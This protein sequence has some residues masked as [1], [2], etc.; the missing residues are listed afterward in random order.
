MAVHGIAKIM[1]GLKDFHFTTIK[2][3]FI[4]RVQL[5]AGSRL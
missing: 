4:L 3:A 2:L 1:T 5:Q